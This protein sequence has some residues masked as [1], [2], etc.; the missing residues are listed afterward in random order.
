MPKCEICNE[1]F[2]RKEA[3][4]IFI[5]ETFLLSYDNIKRC[6]CGS[7][8]VELAE[9]GF[10]EGDYIEICEECGKEYDYC[11]AQYEYMKAL[12]ERHFDTINGNCDIR[13]TWDD[14]N[15]ILCSDCAIKW[16]DENHEY[17][18]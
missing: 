6:L 5:E 4:G 8:A 15:Q 1:V 13:D 12:E 9:S 3:E 18:F 7:C 11:T 17:D 16:F 14:A 2:D 10:N